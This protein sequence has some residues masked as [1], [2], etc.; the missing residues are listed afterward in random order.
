MTTRMNNRSLT[1]EATGEGESP[2]TVRSGGHD[3]RVG[4]THQDMAQAGQHRAP[5]RLTQ[6]PQGMLTT[7]FRQRLSRFNRRRADQTKRTKTELTVTCTKYGFSTLSALF[8]FRVVLVGT[9]DL[10][11]CVGPLGSFSYF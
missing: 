10:Q 1:K 5:Q 8:C 9:R 6:M 2:V 4:A 11:P 3:Q 7:A